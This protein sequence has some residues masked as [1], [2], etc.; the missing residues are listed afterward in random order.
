MRNGRATLM[1]ALSPLA[2]AALA[3]TGLLTMQ[4]SPLEAQQDTIE[5]EP[6]EARQAADTLEAARELAVDAAVVTTAVTDRRPADTLSTVEADVGQVYLWTRITGAEGETEVVHVWYR[7]DEEM[8]RV[9]L[10]VASPSW[11]TWSS[12]NILPA[13]TGRWRV[14]VEGPD[15]SVLET[16]SF[17]VEE[18]P[19]AAPDAPPETPPAAAG[20]G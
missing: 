5:A 11:R 17:T 10:R 3:A 9:P 4:M 8:A 2:L 16:V 1:T 13:W 18:S 7:G 12:K 19:A 14:E 6:V 15:G 20:K